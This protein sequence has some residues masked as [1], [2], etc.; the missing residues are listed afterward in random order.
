MSLQKSKSKTRHHIVC[1]MYMTLICVSHEACILPYPRGL[2]ILQG[3]H[4][5]QDKYTSPCRLY[6]NGVFYFVKYIKLYIY[7]ERCSYDTQCTRG[8]NASNQ[9]GIITITAKNT[10]YCTPT[11]YSCLPGYKC[12]LN[13]VT[14][15]VRV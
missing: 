4:N 10:L 7:T 15:I 14:M 3:E 1:H 11:G 9:T 12:I 13:D 2:Y 8:Y 5:Q 6:E